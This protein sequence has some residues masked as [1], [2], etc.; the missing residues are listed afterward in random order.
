MGNSNCN[1]NYS[2]NAIATLTS[3]HVNGYV[4]FHQCNSHQPVKVRFI[5][6]GPPNQ[7]H[8]IHIHEYGDLRKGC[9]SLGSH[10]NP[11]NKTHGSIYYNMSR[12]AGD[13]INNLDFDENGIF[14]YEYNES[15]ISLYQNQK[16]I[17]GRS[18]V[19]HEKEDDLG[20]GLGKNKEESLKTGNSGKRI[21]CAVI[22]LA[23]EEHF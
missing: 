12:H 1:Q 4:L 13:L 22:G 21:C 23:K 17:L 2:K 3:F 20:L 10:F 14:D 8:A 11:T 16:C 18:I 6:R 15:E 5:I 9:E 7:T 19:I